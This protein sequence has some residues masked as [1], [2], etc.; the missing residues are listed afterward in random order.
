MKHWLTEIW[1]MLI[2]R[3]DGPLTFRFVF[4]PAVAAILAIRAG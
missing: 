4:Q 3:A 2:G 1:T